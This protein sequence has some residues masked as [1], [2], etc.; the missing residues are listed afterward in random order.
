MKKIQIT[1]LMLL[2]LSTS[3]LLSN[4]LFKDVVLNVGFNTFRLFSNNSSIQSQFVYIN[5][6]GYSGGGLSYIEPGLDISTTLFLD[7]ENVHRLLVGV[8]YIGMNAKEI[9]SWQN[10]AYY[11]KYHQ[12]NFIDGYLGYHYSFY[13]AP[14]QNVRIY[15]GLELMFNNIIYNKHQSGLKKVQNITPPYPVEEEESIY[16]KPT[17]FRFGSRIRAGFEGRI[18]E[19]IYLGGSFTVGI[20]NLFDRDD[21]T[22]E[23]FNYP[24]KL[25]K[26]ESFQPFFNFLISVQ[27]R[28]NDVKEK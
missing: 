8:E 16:S 17:T 20:Y 15:S 12:V 27:Y 4:D 10:F 13:K 9:K 26:G 18:K 14:W 6:L 24:S 23:L 28:F 22:G 2:L 25:D 19:K 11:Y 3:F 7:N 1:T 5:G 21:S